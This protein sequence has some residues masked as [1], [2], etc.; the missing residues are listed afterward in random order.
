MDWLKKKPDTLEFHLAH[1]ELD[2]SQYI[3]AK[4]LKMGREIAAHHRIYLDTKQWLQLRDVAMGR[5]RNPIHSEIFSRLLFLRSTKSVLCPISSSVFMELMTQS[6]DET[7]IATA[8]VIDQL[9]DG[10]CCLP[11][12]TLTERELMY[13]M[14]EKGLGGK[15]KQP[16]ILHAVWTKVPFVLGET[17]SVSDELPADVMS[18]MQR[19]FDDL[20]CSATV[21]EFVTQLGSEGWERQIEEER[22]LVEQLSEGKTLHANDHPTFHDLLCAEIYGGLDSLRDILEEVMVQVARLSGAT[23]EVPDFERKS[24]GQLLA[25]LVT[26]AF[27]HRKIGN[28][29]PQIHIHAALHAALRWDK[30]R[31]YDPND[32]EDI[33]HATVALPYYHLFCTERG[34]CHQITQKLCQLDK[35][36]GTQVVSSDEEFLDCVQSIR[37]T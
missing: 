36:Y 22:K 5:P 19:S 10:C 6:D 25:N 37:R 16:P 35:I 4:R 11:P 26:N 7:R 29:L 30:H 31:K 27:R 12:L 8:K 23:G 28:Q 32:F 1:P 14:I 21:E 2:A 18:A 33:R 34:L 13:F 15:P 24:G 20:F 3:Q 17:M 9:A